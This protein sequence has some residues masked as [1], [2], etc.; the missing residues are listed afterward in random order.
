M[1][2]EKNRCFE[3]TFFLLTFSFQY[4]QAEKEQVPNRSQAQQTISKAPSIKLELLNQTKLK[5][6]LDSDDVRY[7]KEPNDSFDKANNTKKISVIVK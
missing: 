2:I 4:A 1:R 3:V 7:E 5:Q 6:S